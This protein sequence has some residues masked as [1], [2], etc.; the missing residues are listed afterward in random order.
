MARQGRR[1]VREHERR[2]AEQPAARETRLAT[3]HQHTHERRA[4]EQPE[5]R[6]ARLERRREHNR[7]QRAAEQAEARGLHETGRLVD[8]GKLKRPQQTSMP[9]LED[10]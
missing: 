10:E 4:A 3:D 7:E 6:Q 8:E 9:A 5:A 1:R 2:A